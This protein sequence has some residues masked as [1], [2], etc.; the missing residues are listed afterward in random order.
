VAG[1]DVALEGRAAGQGFLFGD[2]VRERPAQQGQ[3]AHP[4]GELADHAQDGL[5]GEQGDQGQR[6]Q[7]REHQ[8]G[9]RAEQRP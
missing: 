4:G 9:H 3:R 2:A 5:A 7:Q 6:G 1:G 8:T